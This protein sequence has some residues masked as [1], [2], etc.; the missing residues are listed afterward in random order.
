[1]TETEIERHTETYLGRQRQSKRQTETQRD[2]PKEIR[3][4]E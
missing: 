3:E 1:M 4:I 2:R